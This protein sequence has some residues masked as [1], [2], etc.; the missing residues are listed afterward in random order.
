MKVRF[1]GKSYKVLGYLEQTKEHIIGKCENKN[2]SSYF[3]ARKF[4]YRLSIIFLTK[5]TAEAWKNFNNISFLDE[6]FE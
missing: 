4:P 1:N 2:D 6:D 3:V 5:D